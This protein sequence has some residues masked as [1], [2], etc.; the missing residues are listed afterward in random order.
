LGSDWRDQ[1]S[2][3]NHA[4]IS[5]K[6]GSHRTNFTDVVML[7]V[8]REQLKVKEPIPEAID[9]LLR[10]KW[11]EENQSDVIF[12]HPRA[13]LIGK[14]L[15]RWDDGEKVPSSLPPA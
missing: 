2:A 13:T 8:L 5:G 10:Y 14:P 12:R 6:S 4:C 11:F 1:G 7:S 3:E 15:G 9:Q